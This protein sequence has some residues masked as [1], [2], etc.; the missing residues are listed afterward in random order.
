MEHKNETGLKAHSRWMRSIF[1]CRASSRNAV[2]VNWTSCCSSAQYR[3]WNTV[4]KSSGHN[5]MPLPAHFQKICGQTTSLLRS[6]RTHTKTK[7]HI[8]AE[9]PFSAHV[10]WLNL[11]NTSQKSRKKRA[12]WCYLSCFYCLS[13][14]CTFLTPCDVNTLSWKFALSGSLVWPSSTKARVSL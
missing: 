10:W 4:L 1:W 9:A 11:A 12:F 8:G 14:E 13:P 5:P 2:E 3:S 6:E 7:R